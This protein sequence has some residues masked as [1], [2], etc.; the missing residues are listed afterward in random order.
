MVGDLPYGI[1]HGNTGGKKHGGPTR[2]PLEL[3]G[4]CLQEWYQVLKTGGAAVLAW[5]ALVAP[6]EQV[7]DLFMQHGFSVQND[8]P[9]DDFVHT[10]DRS[11]K[12][13]VLVARKG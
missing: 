9:F 10:V 3:L 1:F 8:P 11:I 5:N 4:E 7:V 13:D 12:R 2:N 6:R